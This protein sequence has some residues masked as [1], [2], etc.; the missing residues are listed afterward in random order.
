MLARPVASNFGIM[1]LGRLS[2][3]LLR[4]LRL[5]GIFQI[6]GILGKISEGQGYTAGG[7]SKMIFPVKDKVTLLEVYLK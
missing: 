7:I 4:V 1:A 2:R 6:R 5:V 3:T